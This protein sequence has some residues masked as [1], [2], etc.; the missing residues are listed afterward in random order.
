MNTGSN[1]MV[2]LSDFV[3]TEIKPK[4]R[5]KVMALQWCRTNKIKYD[6]IGKIMFIRIDEP[7][8]IELILISI[9]IDAGYS[10]VFEP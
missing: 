5:E 1:P 7:Q 2:P 8:D 9:D 10:I 4:K 6:V 3:V